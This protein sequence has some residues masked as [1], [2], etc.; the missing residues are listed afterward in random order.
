MD[1]Q[2]FRQKS[3]DH[4]S[5]PEQLHDYMRVTSPRLWMV[6]G[7]IVLL[8]IG[9]IIYASTAKLESR[10]TIPVKVQYGIISGEIPNSMENLIRAGMPVEIKGQKGRIIYIDN[11]LSCKLKLSA[12]SRMPTVEGSYI[13]FF[14]D[15]AI[16]AEN[17]KFIPL[18]A[19]Y[20]PGGLVASGVSD[21]ES[22]RQLQN[23]KTR[24]WV[25]AF[26]ESDPSDIWTVDVEGYDSFGTMTAIMRLEDP[27]TLLEDGTY[28][29]EVVTGT[30][31]PI[32]FL[33]Q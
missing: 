19:D 10:Q 28:D 4:I 5:S 31:T 8:L 1:K 24:I 11:S 15:P 6:M 32:S 30:S 25:T 12:D 29:A 27:E 17:H 26:G 2:L 13:L 9:F 21:P 20:G 14:E 18:V 33:W 22:L 16:D 23:G 3:L 7:A